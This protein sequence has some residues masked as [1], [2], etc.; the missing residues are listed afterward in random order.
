MGGIVTSSFSLC[1]Y[2]RRHRDL[3]LSLLACPVGRSRD[4]GDVTGGL[5]RTNGRAAS[6]ARVGRIEELPAS[7]TL[8]QGL[9]RGGES[10]C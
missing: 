10:A 9:G 4:M 3:T 1:G 7:E 6:E 5:E 8:Y 2:G